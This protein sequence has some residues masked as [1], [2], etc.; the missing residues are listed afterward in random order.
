MGAAYSIDEFSNCKEYALVAKY[1]KMDNNWDELSPNLSN[2][3]DKQMS[4]ITPIMVARKNYRGEK[5]DGI[6]LY[7]TYNTD[8]VRLLN[9][10][11]NSEL[12]KYKLTVSIV[13]DGYILKKTYVKEQQR[14]A[15]HYKALLDYLENGVDGEIYTAVSAE[16]AKMR[17]PH[18]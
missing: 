10:T 1:N 14:L 11:W 2:L 13:N 15:I 17:I 5:N 3:S 8:L 4:D 12:R 16:L 7:W 18:T 6:P 9:V